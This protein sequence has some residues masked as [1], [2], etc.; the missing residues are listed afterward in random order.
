MLFEPAAEP[1]IAGVVGSLAG[2]SGIVIS[3]AG[4]SGG[5]LAGPSGGYLA[6]PSGSLCSRPGDRLSPSVLWQ[7]S[8]LGGAV[9]RAV[10]GSRSL[11]SPP[12]PSRSSSRSSSSSSYGGIRL[13]LGCD[14]VVEPVEVLGG[15][16]VDVEPPVT[17][18][19]L[20]LEEGAVGAEEGVLGQAAAPV[21][22][23]DVE[24]LALGL[25]VPVVTAVNLPVAHK[26][27]LR[28]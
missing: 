20:L 15:G 16:A 12:A 23:A 26:G 24:G 9:A 17:D 4:P 13:P 21:P 10:V 22:G 6:G 25:G 7:Q 28:G 18:E 11:P 8:H 2:P 27:A 1:G 14:L 5:S 19:V 3:L